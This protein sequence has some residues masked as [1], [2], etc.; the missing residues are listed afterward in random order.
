MPF[1]ILQKT[2]LQKKILKF[3]LTTISSTKKHQL[4]TPSSFTNVYP[5][6]FLFTVTSTNHILQQA[7]LTASPDPVLLSTQIKSGADVIRSA[8]VFLPDPHKNSR[9]PTI[10]T[11]E[12][13]RDTAFVVVRLL[14]DLA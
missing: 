9:R 5:I 8:A 12:T 3:F 14:S 11:A 2:T 1:S 4:H 7:G 13:T 10:W 6:P